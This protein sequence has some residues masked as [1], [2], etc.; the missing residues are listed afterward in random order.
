[1]GTRESTGYGMDDRATVKRGKDVFEARRREATHPTTVGW[2]RCHVP[3]LIKEA[4]LA[5]FTPASST[6]LHPPIPR[7]LSFGPSNTQSQTLC[8]VVRAGHS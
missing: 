1:M 3:R 7:F 2:F 4:H 5:T 8:E 6:R